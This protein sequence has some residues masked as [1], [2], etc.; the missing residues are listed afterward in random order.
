MQIQTELLSTIAPA[1]AVADGDLP[2]ID[3]RIMNDWRSD[4]DMEDVL[5]ILA[6]VPAECTRS[7]GDFRK[8]IAAGDLASVRRTA[9]RLKGMANNLGAVRLA[10]IA[11]S[12]ELG[13]QSIEAVSS[14]MAPL[15]QALEETLEALRSGC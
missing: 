14:R 3:Q 2:L 6:R 12:I 7:L 1:D 10:R 9:H 11:R 15:E 4:M 13:C 8:A 5:S